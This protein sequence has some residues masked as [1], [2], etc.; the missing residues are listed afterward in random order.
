MDSKDLKKI[1][2]V[3]RWNVS[4]METPS[5]GNCLFHAILN[6]YSDQYR[7][8]NDLTTK[9][10]IVL[11]LRKNLSAKLPTQR[12]VGNDPSVSYYDT[13]NGGNTKIFA[14]EVP[15]FSL[16]AMQAQLCSSTPIGYGYLEYIGLMLNKDIYILDAE[17]N[18]IYHSDEMKYS[19]TGK[20]SS[21]V[22][23][24]DHGH[25]ELTGIYNA[26]QIHTIFH[27]N[28]SWVRFLYKKVLKFL[29]PQEHAIEPKTGQ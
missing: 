14:T 6:A 19:I 22:V 17:T 27:P 16:S 12:S 20:R 15:E 9:R 18:D 3:T 10:S 26:S 8:A 28:H 25:Y 23:L 4:S 5:D 13:L 11:N 29:N 7:E 2:W 24:Y 1:L 21:I